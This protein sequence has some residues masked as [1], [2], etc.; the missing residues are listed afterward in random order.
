VTVIASQHRARLVDVGEHR[1]HRNTGWQYLARVS[2]VVAMLVVGSLG[3]GPFSSASAQT[4]QA[5]TT[6]VVTTATV[7][8]TTVT[9]TEAGPTGASTTTTVL[10]G[11]SVNDRSSTRK[12]QLITG[13]LTALGLLF[14]GLVVWYWRSTKPVPA[15]LEGLDLLATR[16]FQKAPD[17]VRDDLLADLDAQRPEPSQAAIVP[18]AQI[19]PVGHVGEIAYEE[20]EATEVGRS[21][22]ARLVVAPSSVA[23]SSGAPS[24][25]AHE[26]Q[27]L[28]VSAG[29]PLVSPD[30]LLADVRSMHEAEQEN[31]GG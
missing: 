27:H 20:V 26:A 24:S 18:G 13:A 16:K 6:T 7:T 31:H 22:G 12:I 23:P 10:A 28:H 11:S 3:L 9:T 25:V 21:N 30:P 14:G 5:A 17:D 29:S 15:H 2:A 8:T 1:T 19:L 4:D